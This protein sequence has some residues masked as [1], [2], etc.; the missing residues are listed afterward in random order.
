MAVVSSLAWTPPACADGS[1]CSASV[2]RGS[3]AGSEGVWTECQADTD[4]AT[5]VT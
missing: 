4:L 3:E 1:C 2:V 5:G